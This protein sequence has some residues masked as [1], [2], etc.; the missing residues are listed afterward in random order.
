MEELVRNYTLL[1]YE[2]TD[3]NQELSDNYY[4]DLLKLIEKSEEKIN[5][6][7]MIYVSQNIVLL[8]IAAVMPLLPHTKYAIC[9]GRYIAKSTESDFMPENITLEQKIYQ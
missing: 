8:M 4:N 3:K 9:N 7:I 5:S 6:K 1:K 2:T